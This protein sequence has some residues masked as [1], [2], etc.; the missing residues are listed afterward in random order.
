MKQHRGLA[1][2]AEASNRLRSDLENV[3]QNLHHS[4][5][6]SYLRRLVTPFLD[7]TSETAANPTS[8]S[9]TSPQCETPS[10][11]EIGIERMHGENAH[12][13][14]TRAVCTQSM[15]VVDVRV[16]AERAYMV[17]EPWQV[18]ASS[19]ELYE[20]TVQSSKRRVV[21]AKINFTIPSPHTSAC[22]CACHHHTQLIIKQVKTLITSHH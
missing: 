22:T 11:E 20:R 18:V 16:M 17:L 9:I 12:E 4:A 19:T 14:P 6:L 2:T 5:A 3:G 8:L 15:V 13:A 7:L 21:L 10:A 1:S